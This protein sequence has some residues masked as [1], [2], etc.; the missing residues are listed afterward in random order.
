M[1]TK[2][3]TKTN[4]FVNAV[5]FKSTTFTENGAV[6]NVTTGSAIVDQFGKA[7][8]FRGRPLAE[9]FADQAKIWEENPEAALRFPFYLRM[10]TR[11]VKV[12]A[13]NETD[14]VQ[15]GQG[16]RDESFKRLLWIAQEQPEAFYNN[17][18]A[19]PLVGSWKDLWTL[20]FYDTK[21]KLNCLNQKSLF[22]IIAQGLLCDTHT[23]LIK[24]Y[25]PRIKSYS[26]CKTEW[27]KTTNE[28]AKAF[29]THMGI[30]YKEYNKMKS[31]GNAH[32]F[33]KLI[34]SRNYKDL[35]WN[36]IPGRALN[37]LV[38]SKF[39]TNHNLR[40]EY[41][42][43]ILKQPVAKFTGYVFELGKRL[44]EAIGGSYYRYGRK[45]TPN[46]PLELKHTLDAQF[47][48]LV[49]KARADGKINENVWCCLDT[50]GSMNQQVKGLKDI[51]CSDVA[52]SLA[53]FFADLNTGPFH[54]KLIMFD[55]VSTPYDMKGE[56]FCDRV[57]SLPNVSCGGT[58]FQSAVDEI[59]KIREAHPE[60]PLEQYPTTILVVSDMQ[61][62][63]TNYS[64]Y[65][66]SPRR[67]DTNYEYSVKKLKEVFPADFVDN[68]K[69]IWWDC[70]SRYGTTDFEGTI[71]DG[72]C[73][74]FSGFDGSI[75]NI[76][77]NE[78]AVRDEK[79]GEIRRPTA[80]ELVAKALSQEILNY[81]KL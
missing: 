24:K 25:M 61:F 28:L 76:L 36:H 1:N 52:T 78:D 6:T 51:Y 22:E 38:S 45:G 35:N 57:L 56:S 14:K 11:K 23:D 44:R 20:M 37:L 66:S 46:I 15:S 10:I 4:A 72:G 53:L 3:A 54:N 50:S 74:F 30:T 27:T 8:N 5:N 69:F 31:S 41:T 77:M 9:V 58:N 16:A 65:G 62:N 79:T 26:K 40:D 49:D 48:G 13:D 32:D 12:N 63:P 43:W 64:Y 67:Q 47:K 60:I 21:E 7:G 59:I 18:W 42:Q 70:A 55:N 19:L 75:I 33:Q 2:T 81:I 68:M 29:A 71:H 80:E 73:Y 34:C 17:I 39:L